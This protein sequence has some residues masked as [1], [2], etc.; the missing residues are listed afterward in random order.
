MLWLGGNV[1]LKRF[2]KT[3]LRILIFF[4][5]LL[6]VL[7]VLFIAT[8]K[9]TAIQTSSPVG[10]T[11]LQYIDENRSRELTLYIWYPTDETETVTLFEDNAVFRGFSAIENAP[12][13]DSI[14][15]LIV[16][17]HGSGGN[18]A[19]QGW[20]AVE[21][22]RQGAIV[23][24]MNHP[25]ST[26]R[27]SAPATN[28]LTW[29]RPADVSFVLDSL[30]ADEQFSASI[31]PDRIAIVG[32]SLG[33]YTALA[34]GGAELSLDKFIDYCD[35]F[36]NSPDCM[37]FNR[38]GVDLTQVDRTMFER[39]NRDERVKAIVS[40]DPAYARSFEADSLATLTDTLLIAPTSE[41]GTK[42]DLH[43]AKLAKE[44]A[45]THEF[46]ELEGA[47]HFTFL[48]ECKAA[49]Y[50]VLMVLERGGEL[51][52]RKEE[53]KARAEYHNETAKIVIDFL[54]EKQIFNPL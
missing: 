4:A 6:V 35:G 14:Y 43:V 7:V 18:S 28:I 34:V 45:P 52:C 38:G 8:N 47:Q 29:N 15:P 48:P 17:S 51:L 19:N 24:A 11:D 22:A 31:D 3:I 12:V 25:G 26:S 44:L 41:K 50:Y 42:N 36:S 53:K 21:L 5:I 37:F 32:H 39:S 54:K 20:L 13:S 2:F 40:I 16:L 27:D 33:G 30:L 23:V 1:A 10:F 49:G 9:P 46:V